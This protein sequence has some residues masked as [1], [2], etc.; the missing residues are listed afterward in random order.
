[1]LR[2]AHLLQAAGEEAGRAL[3]GAGDGDDLVAEVVEH[4]DGE[5]AERATALPAQAVVL[6]HREEHVLAQR[7]ADLVLIVALE[8]GE[9]CE[10]GE[11]GFR[12]G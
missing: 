6:L 4:A 9:G 3:E 2:S 10:G 7:V 1:M 8:A 12:P 11:V 5:R